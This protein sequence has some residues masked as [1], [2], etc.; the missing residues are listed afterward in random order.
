M[1][2]D[3]EATTEKTSDESNANLLPAAKAPLE[4]ITGSKPTTKNSFSP[5]HYLSILQD[6][7]PPKDKKSSSDT[8]FYLETSAKEYKFKNLHEAVNNKVLYEDE[9]PNYLQQVRALLKKVTDI[10]E[11]LDWELGGI[12]SKKMYN[13]VTALHIA[14][15]HYASIDHYKASFKLMKLLLE[16]G[17]DVNQQ[18]NEGNAPLYYATHHQ[19]GEEFS[20]RRHPTDDRGKRSTMRFL[21]EQ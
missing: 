10:N 19:G 20:Y 8:L 21:L 17:A 13:G 1:L 2:Q 12:V 6:L 14:S 3:L 16:F 4:K 5:S 7:L 9:D 11:K 18:D 15:Y